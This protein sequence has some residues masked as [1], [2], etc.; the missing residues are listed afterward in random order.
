MLAS[1]WN[2]RQDVFQ[3]RKT[4]TGR[5][6][7]IYF[8]YGYNRLVVRVHDRILNRSAIY[9]NVIVASQASRQ[10]NNSRAEHSKNTPAIRVHTKRGEP[11]ALRC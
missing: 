2:P 1:S 4:K 10:L 8:P 3:G 11:L 5:L 9:F 6:T 7:Q